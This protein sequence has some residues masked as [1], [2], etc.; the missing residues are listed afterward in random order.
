MSEY[1]KFHKTLTTIYKCWNSEEIVLHIKVH[2]ELLNNFH[3]LEI[4]EF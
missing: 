1:L 3:I 2:L 4:L